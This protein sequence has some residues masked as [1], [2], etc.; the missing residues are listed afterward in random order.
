[1]SKIVKAN[2]ESYHYL[3]SWNKMMKNSEEPLPMRPF[4]SREEADAYIRG[5]VDVICMGSKDN[6]QTTDVAKDFIVTFA[7]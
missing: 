2:G 7:Q 3:V 6:L 4:K 5:C 1:M